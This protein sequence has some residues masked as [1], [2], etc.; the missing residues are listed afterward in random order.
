MDLKGKR[1][2]IP[3]ISSTPIDHHSGRFV[4]HGL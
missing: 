1:Y 3:M 4:P 2:I